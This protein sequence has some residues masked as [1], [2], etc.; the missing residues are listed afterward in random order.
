MET[1]QKVISQWRREGGV[2]LLG[3]EM[4]RLLA[5][6]VPSLGGNRMANKRKKPAKNQQPRG[7]TTINLDE[8]EREM[9]ALIG[10]QDRHVSTC[11]QCDF[12][13]SAFFPSLPHQRFSRHCVVPGQTWWSVTRGTGLRMMSQTSPRL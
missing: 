8:T 2:L 12:F 1:R 9:D 5:L 13:L 10:M 7:E 4:Y 11:L 3:Y 6:S